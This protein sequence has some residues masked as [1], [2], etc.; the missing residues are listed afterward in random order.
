MFSKTKRS[1]A[2]VAAGVERLVKLKCVGIN[3]YLVHVFPFI[4]HPLSLFDVRPGR[5]KLTRLRGYILG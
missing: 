3:K 4:I 5:V 2:E 1:Y